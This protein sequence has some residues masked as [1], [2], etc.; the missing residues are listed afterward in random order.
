MQHFIVRRLPLICTLFCLTLLTAQCGA[1][2]EPTPLAI[3]TT[4][5]ELRWMTWDPSS[6]VETAAIAQFQV[7]HPQVTFKRQEVNA[8]PLTYLTE[9]PLPDLLTTDVEASLLTAIRQNQV[10]DLTEVWTNTGL[11]D[12]LPASL[13]KLSEIDGKH[14]YLPVG[15]SWQVIYYNKQI[16]AQYNLQP[17][18]TWDEFLLI[19][20]TLKA[21]GEAPL[22][23]SGN[24]SFTSLYWFEYLNLRLNGADFHR[25]LLAG[26]ISFEDQRVR[27]VLETWA[28]LLTSGY[29]VEGSYLLSELGS[30]N[31]LIRSDNGM[32]RGPKAVMALS[33]P[34]NFS[35]VPPK[36]QA[37]M[38]FF[39]FPIIDP[40]IPTA[41]IIDLF[42]YVIPVG[43]D[44]L[45]QALD[46]VTFMGS[47]EAQSLL[48][49]Q[50]FAQS[51]IYAPA[52]MDID[53]DL[54]S[55]QQ[56]QVR[57]LVQTAD[58]AVVPLFY[59]LPR[60]MWSQMLLGYNKFLRESH[61]VDL[62]TQRL[63]EARQKALEQGLF[64]E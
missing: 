27:R 14:Y 17:P 9:S 32:L 58:D 35:D 11:F 28:S 45:P 39:R 48:A 60:M 53:P 29:V 59:A 21:N 55:P 16:F 18:Q 54:L 25:E 5:V 33:D 50:P 23:F 22:A 3:A 46:F 42:G 64:G 52:R 15:F 6:Q 56:R 36:F 43:A 1:E 19:C 10:A 30:I 63:E 47:I 20:D 7:T 34:Y 57:E 31:S 62:Y 41:E 40:T 12:Q 13:Q 26:R 51:R 49:Q 37:E 8:P 24:D 2:E 4:P 61:D 44:H 38:D